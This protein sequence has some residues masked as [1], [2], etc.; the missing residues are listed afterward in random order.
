MELIFRIIFYSFCSWK[1]ILQTNSEE[2]FCLFSFWN[3]LI[4]LI[5]FPNFP[6]ILPLAKFDFMLQ[7]WS[8]GVNSDASVTGWDWVWKQFSSSQ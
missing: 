3:E 5:D 6:D 2:R 4:N 7:R 8:G 1:L